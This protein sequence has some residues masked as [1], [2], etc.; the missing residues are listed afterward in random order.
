[1][2]RR[3]GKDI[4]AHPLYIG[5]AVA[6]LLWLFLLGGTGGNLVY[7]LGVNVRGVNPLNK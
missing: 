3:R 1:M 6:G 4:S 2:A 7:Q 5:I